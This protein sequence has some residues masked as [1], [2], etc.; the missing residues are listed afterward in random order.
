MNLW[1]TTLGILLLLSTFKATLYVE[2]HPMDAASGRLFA[3]AYSMLGLGTSPGTLGFKVL[4]D[5]NS[6]SILDTGFFLTQPLYHLLKGRQWL[7]DLLALA[8]SLSL[9]IGVLCKFEWGR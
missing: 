8:N 3:S 4:A 7:N 2:S 1:R 9:L 6:N 5:G